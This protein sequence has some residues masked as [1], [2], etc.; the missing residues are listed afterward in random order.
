MAVSHLPEVGSS[1]QNRG[2]YEFWTS[3]RCTDLGLEEV[4]SPDRTSCLPALLFATVMR[5]YLASL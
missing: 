3:V 2:G 5:S 1:L 4:A